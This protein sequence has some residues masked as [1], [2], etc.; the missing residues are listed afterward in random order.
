MALLQVMNPPF[1]ISKNGIVWDETSNRITYV[2]EGSPAYKAGIRRCRCMVLEVRDECYVVQKLIDET[3]RSRDIDLPRH[4]GELLRRDSNSIFG[5]N[6][7]LFSHE[8]SSSIDRDTDVHYG[9]HT[10][11]TSTPEPARIRY[12]ESDLD[13][14]HNARK[15]NSAESSQAQLQ[16]IHPQRTDRT[17]SELSD[18]RKTRPQTWS[19]D[20][21][22]QALDFERDLAPSGTSSKLSTS[23]MFYQTLLSFT[24]ML[25]R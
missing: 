19:M 10:T 12:Q 20:N 4:H 21:T 17:T 7:T 22:S 15:S 5:L 3:N 23:W 16:I 18:L 14:H 8:N 25:C 2:A 9:S 1:E 11:N 13:N 24:N 6:A